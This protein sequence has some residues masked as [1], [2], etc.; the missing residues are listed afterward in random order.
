MFLWIE[1]VQ[2][3]LI[4]NLENKKNR[5]SFAI[6]PQ[7]TQ[8]ILEILGVSVIQTDGCVTPITDVPPSDPVTVPVVEVQAAGRDPVAEGAHPVVWRRP[9]FLFEEHELSCE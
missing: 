1:K 5:V 4:Y 8:P 9:V 6:P 3:L 2:I 7:E